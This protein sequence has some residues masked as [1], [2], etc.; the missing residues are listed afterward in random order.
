MKNFGKEIQKLRV[1][2]NQT[3]REVAE[4]LA[5]K[6]S[7]LSDVEHGRKKPFKPSLLNKFVEHFNCDPKPLEKL[8]AKG[9]NSIEIELDD[10]NPVVSR[11]AF[12]LARGG[13]DPIKAQEMLDLLEG[14]G[15][16]E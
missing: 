4:A 13:I 11:L 6:I 14:E 5:I 8:A 10:K 1:E 7:F 2:A 12:A 16:E 15:K 9:R 3:L